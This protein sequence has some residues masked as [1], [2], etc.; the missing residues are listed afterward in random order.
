MG[1]NFGRVVLGGILAGIV[2]NISETVLNMFVIKDANEA[3]MKALGK[4]M[5]MD[6]STIMIWVVW[7]FVL[8]I[9]IVQLYAAI[10]PRFGA[11]P[12]TAAKAGIFCWFLTSVLTM[13]AMQNMGLFAFN[14]VVAVWTLVESILAAV[15]GA[16]LYKEEG[17][18]A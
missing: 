18:A 16:W 1:I 9:A 2:I 6:G 14:F 5:P 12:R 15:A 13:I 11:G 7:G 8:G 3:A 10:R 4:T 17:A